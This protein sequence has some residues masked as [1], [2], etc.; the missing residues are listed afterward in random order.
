MVLFVLE[1]NWQA[2][3]AERAKNERLTG[4][5]GE[6]LLLAFG[7][8]LRLVDVTL[9]AEIGLV[10]MVEGLIGQRRSTVRTDEAVWM[11]ELPSIFSPRNLRREVKLRLTFTGESFGSELSL[12]LATLPAED[13]A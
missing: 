6:N 7:T 3:A 5:A 2:S 12:A 9:L 13:V 1:G 4:F 8:G 10:V 11:I